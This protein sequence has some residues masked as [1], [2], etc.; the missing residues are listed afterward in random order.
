[1]DRTPVVSE[2]ASDAQLSDTI[3][4]PGSVLDFVDAHRH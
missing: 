4:M 1:V 3:D 2:I